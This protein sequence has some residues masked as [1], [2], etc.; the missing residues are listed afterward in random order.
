LAFWLRLK[1]CEL[2]TSVVQVVAALLVNLYATAPSFAGRLQPV[3]LTQLEES[4]AVEV[5]RSSDDLGLHW[6]KATLE[7]RIGWVNNSAPIMLCVSLLSLDLLL[8]PP[9]VEI[10][11]LQSE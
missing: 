2:A 11:W 7:Q 9:L 4:A 5:L 6:A 8:I 1:S 10:S 3:R